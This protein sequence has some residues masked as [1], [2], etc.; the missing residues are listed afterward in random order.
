MKKGPEDVPPLRHGVVS[1]MNDVDRC[2]RC[3]E[4]LEYDEVDIGVGT[5][6]GNPGCPS[7]HW[8]PPP[9]GL[10]EDVE[11][12]IMVICPK[13]GAEQ[14]DLDGFGVL[15]CPKCGYCSHASVTGDICGLC[16]QKVSS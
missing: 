3:G 9:F 2:P 16:G 14:Q 10:E 5:M 8:T 1:A 4:P 12:A 6:R 11:I 15:H 7:C 13:C